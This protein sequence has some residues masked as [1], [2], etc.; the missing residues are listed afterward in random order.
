MDLEQSSMAPLKSPASNFSAPLLAYFSDSEVAFLDV[1]SEIQRLALS[2]PSFA[3]IC[4]SFKASD[5]L[6]NSFFKIPLL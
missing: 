1:E 6:P 4:I 3:A 5:P 2:N